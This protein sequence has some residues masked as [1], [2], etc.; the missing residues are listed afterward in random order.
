MGT[1]FFQGVMHA[2]LGSI[3]VVWYLLAENNSNSSN[4][5]F[6]SSH[7]TLIVD[8][9]LLNVSFCDEDQCTFIS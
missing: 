9:I 8:F 6:S 2:R 1:D 3:K 5:T 7:M 4:F